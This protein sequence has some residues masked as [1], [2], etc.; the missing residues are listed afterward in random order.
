M[1]H[2]KSWGGQDAMALKRE[3]G[4]SVYL[5]NAGVPIDTNHLER[6]IRPIPL[7]RKNWLFCWTEV[8]AH[9]VAIAQT[10]IA[11]CKLHGVNSFEYFVDVLSKVDSHPAARVHE[12][13]PREWAAARKNP[14]TV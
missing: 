1:S 13:T 4:L 6:E 9:A 8:G 14:P 7:G 12:L 10:L 5:S 2:L 3:Q 11:C